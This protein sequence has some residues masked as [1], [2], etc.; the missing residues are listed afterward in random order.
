MN[1]PTKTQ[2]LAEPNVELLPLASI[3]LSE[4]EVQKLRRAKYDAGALEELAASIRENGV[5]MPILVRPRPGPGGA[6][7]QIVAGERRWRASGELGLETIPAVVRD[8]IDDRAAIELALVE[9]LQRADLNPIEEAEAYRSLQQSFGLTQEEI[10]D[11]VGKARPAVANTLRL[12]RL[13]AAVQDY[14]RSG[15]L[16]E[17]QARPLLALKSE[18]E[19]LRLALRAVREGLSARKMEELSGSTSGSRSPS[20]MKR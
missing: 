10:A 8:D 5:L 11:R 19:M 14:L 12:L 13:P 2:H 9:N 16:S 7:Y 1:A 15:E 17:G 18:E 3:A 4:T 20:P 6:R